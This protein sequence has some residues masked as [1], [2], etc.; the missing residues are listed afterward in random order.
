MYKPFRHTRA[1]FHPG[2]TVWN[3]YRTGNPRGGWVPFPD[4]VVHPKNAP[5]LRHDLRNR[6][7][8][9]C[10]E[11]RWHLG[12]RPV[13][14]RLDMVID[15]KHSNVQISTGKAYEYSAE[16]SVNGMRHGFNKLT[17]Q[18]RE[19]RSAAVSEGSAAALKDGT[20]RLIA[21]YNAWTI[22]RA[23]AEVERKL[24]AEVPPI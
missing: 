16:N 21:F 17:R 13:H 10:R 14:R 2:A 5:L 19:D 9:G 8:S 6:S 12:T 11:H 18:S 20:L 24:L 1:G 23:E 22:S 3:W 4:V 7:A 15:N